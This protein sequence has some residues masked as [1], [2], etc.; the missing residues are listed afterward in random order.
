MPVMIGLLLDVDP[1]RMLEALTSN[2]ERLMAIS[3]RAKQAGALHHAFYA[4]VD[5]TEALVVD[6]WESAEAFQ[7][8]FAAGDDIREMMAEAGVR[9][10]P[11]PKFWRELDTPD[12]F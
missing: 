8:F 6:E 10:E 9:G 5:G 2:R 12:K 4:N 11:V 1:E 3:E 7:R